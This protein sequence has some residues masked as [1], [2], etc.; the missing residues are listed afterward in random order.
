MIIGLASAS[1]YCFSRSTARDE[2][3]S[4][5]SIFINRRKPLRPAEYRGE[6]TVEGSGRRWMDSERQST[7]V[8]GQWRAVEGG[9]W[10]VKGRVTRQSDK[11][12]EKQSDKMNRG[13]RTGKGGGRQGCHCPRWMDSKRQWKAVKGQ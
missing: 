5:R 8:K 1:K 9:G 3:E 11:F 2:S 6:R 13:E 12:H 7:A 10:T 4:S